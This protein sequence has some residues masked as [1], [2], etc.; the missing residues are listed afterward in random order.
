MTSAAAP[1]GLMV[2]VVD[3]LAETDF[4]GWEGL[5]FAEVRAKDPEALGAWL[6][7]PDEA[8]PS[9]ESFASVGRRVRRAEEKV[10]AAHPES[11]TVVVSHVTPIKLLICFALEAPASALFRL[12]LDTA[13]VSI[14]DHYA[15]GNSTVVLVNDTSHLR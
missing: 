7:S 4:G 2:E 13:S 8:P 1:L 5:T 12:Q 11:T 6:A 10:I 3:D 14:I 9:G 15:D